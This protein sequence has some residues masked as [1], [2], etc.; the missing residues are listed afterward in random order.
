MTASDI[1]KYNCSKMAGVRK[2]FK[3]DPGELQGSNDVTY[4][5]VEFNLLELLSTWFRKVHL[6][7]ETWHPVTSS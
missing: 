1:K 5:C 2:K 3:W 6:Q 7:N 4:D